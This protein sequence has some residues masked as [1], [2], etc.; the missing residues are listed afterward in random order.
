[1]GLGHQTSVPIGEH[2]FTVE[3][4]TRAADQPLIDTTVYAQGRVMYRRVKS[5]QDLLGNSGGEAEV[6]ALRERIAAQHRGVIDDLR[7]GVL[8]FELPSTQ[9]PAAMLASRGT[10]EFP[11][12]IEVRLLN[13]ASWLVAGT[14][15]LEI[16]VRGRAT[17]LPAVGT[18]VDVSFEGAEPTVR[19]QAGTD[20]RGRVA[21]T[22][23]LPKLGP[24]GG[25]LV[26]RASGPAG[27]DELRF[28]LKPKTRQPDTSKAQT[29]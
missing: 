24:E 3:T 26:I 20:P 9:G 11:A 16:E 21:L 2:T 18:A 13:A 7:S 10:I 14:A 27:Q 23:P 28:R 25:Q 8:R 12:G 1:V 4:E 6:E 5:Y 15:S 29:K 17:L 22:F 19:L